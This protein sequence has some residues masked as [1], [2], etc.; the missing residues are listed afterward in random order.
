MPRLNARI[1]HKA[2]DF[3][4]PL[5]LEHSLTLRKL[6][7]ES[8]KLVFWS[9][10][11]RPSMEAVRDLQQ[12]TG[13]ATGKVLAINAGETPEVA[14]KAAAENGLTATVVT[15]PQRMIS[16]VYG[17]DILPTTVIVN[18]FGLIEAIRYGRFSGDSMTS[19]VGQ[20]TPASR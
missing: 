3:F 8:R 20:K 14:H 19:P 12:T 4:I 7:G 5:D 9:S 2:P 13:K 11:S 1:A 18:K 16:D 17:V 10:K 15:D 6:G